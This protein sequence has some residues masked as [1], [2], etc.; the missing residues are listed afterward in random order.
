MVLRLHPAPLRKNMA[1]ENGLTEAIE[2][3]QD[4]HDAALPT[5]QILS[6]PADFT[7]EVLVKKWDQGEIKLAQGQR[8]FVWNQ[9]KASKLIESFLIGL[10]VPPI[11]L[12]QD[13]E[14]NKLLVVDGQQRLKSIVYFFS[15][16]F[17]EETETHKPE[18]FSLEGLDD[19]SPYRGVTFKKLR[20]NDEASYNKLVN[21]V[22]RSFQMKQILPEDD[23]SIYQVFERLNTGGMILQP[24]EIRN[25]IYDGR[26][27][28]LLKE[29]NKQQA[30]RHV[31]GRPAPDTRMRD[32]ELILRFLAAFYNVANY[33]RPMKKFLNDYM[34]ANRR[35]SHDGRDEFER[36]FTRTTNAVLRVL[37]NRPFHLTRGLNA[38]VYD[39]VFVAFA[40]HL[41]YV[42]RD[43]ISEGE[44]GQIQ[45]KFKAL[46]RDTQYKEWT[47]SHTTDQ[48]VVPNRINKAEQ[49]LF[50][51]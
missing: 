10:P 18:Y 1:K 45:E 28:N 33:K 26:F 3:E 40:R 25:C 48:E 27:N 9:I 30:W 12:Y 17:G 38:A 41:D 36:L 29:L 14:D 19:K 42:S 21:S 22:L 7:L 24:Q 51:N 11:Y 13:P 34:K 50:G 31:I 37:G 49:I 20:D 5:Y 8:N 15:G 44:I 39:S 23:T 4:D 35:P 16:L 6:Y 2:S 32:I 47:V 43:D 46:K